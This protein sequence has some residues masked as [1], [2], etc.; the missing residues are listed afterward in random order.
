[1]HLEPCGLLLWNGLKPKPPNGSGEAI[2]TLEAVGF[3]DRAV[4]S[5]SMHKPTIIGELHRK[6]I[7]FQ[8][9]GE[10]A[11]S[12]SMANKRAQKTRERHSRTRRSFCGH[13]RQLREPLRPR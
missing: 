8:F 10:Y 6:P 12:F 3:L 9:G 11:S 2:R 5:G 1:V 13:S 4:T 7:L